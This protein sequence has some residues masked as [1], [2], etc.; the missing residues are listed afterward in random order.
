MYLLRCTRLAHVLTTDQIDNMSS[1]IHL[2]VVAVYSDPAPHSD[3]A[4]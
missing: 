2:T 1:Y 4:T 3:P